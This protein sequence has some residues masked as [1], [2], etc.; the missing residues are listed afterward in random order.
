MTDGC[1]P[2]VHYTL[3]YATLTLHSLFFLLCRRIPLKKGR[4]ETTI[5]FYNC[6]A[7][8][9]WSGGRCVL[10]KA[11]RAWPLGKDLLC[12]CRGSRASNYPYG[13]REIGRSSSS[14]QIFQ[15]NMREHMHC[16]HDLVV[17]NNRQWGVQPC[18]NNSNS[19]SNIN[20]SSNRSNGYLWGKRR[21]CGSGEVRRVTTTS[22]TRHWAIGEE[23]TSDGVI[24]PISNVSDILKSRCD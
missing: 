23:T 1:L 12:K 17:L 16:M 18:N 15:W 22:E 9:P 21:H 5:F 10:E 11:V 7:P 8:R 2:P 24:V 14:S 19:N 3:H 13:L 20:S 6:T 4:T